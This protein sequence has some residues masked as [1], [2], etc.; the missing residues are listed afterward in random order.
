MSVLKKLASQTVLYGFTY[1]A[2]RLLNFFLTPFYTRI[3]APAAYGAVTEIYAYIAFFNVLYTYGMETGYFYF[4]NKHDNEDEVAGTTFLSLLFS[5]IGLSGLIILFSSQIA[6][7]LGY[8]DRQEYVI[9]TAL[10]L[11]F[12]TLTVI[13]FAYLRKHDKAARFAILKFANIA[14]NI[15]F[16]LFFLVLCPALLARPSYSWLHPFIDAVYRPGFGVGYVFLSNVLA[17][18][19]TLIL[20]LPEIRKIKFRWHKTLWTNIFKYSWPLLILGF[21]GMVN[22]TLDRILLKRLLLQPP[23]NLNLQQAMNELGIYSAAYKLSI[24]MTLAIQSFRYAAEPFFFSQMKEEGGKAIYAQILKYFSFITSLIFLFVMLYIPL[25]SRLLGPAFRTDEGM[26]V[27][28]ILLLA[29]LFAGTFIYLSQ[30]YKQTGKTLYGAMISVGGALITL[31]VNIIFIPYYG[32]LASAWATFACYF[33]MALASYILGQKF[34]P[35]AYN[36]GRIVWY[37]A[38]A[39]LLFLISK[40]IQES[41]FDGWHISVYMINT[42]FLLLYII[43]FLYLEKPVFLLNRIRRK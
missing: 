29:N 30:W 19:L 1:F 17:S 36:T 32:F 13:P 35:V 3:F 23:K 18:L 6:A 24:F 16:N 38:S 33:C 20:L 9:Y 21:A 22:E 27:V 15:A 42:L 34:Y 12:D 26:Q 10:I 28:P 25:F 39:T 11:A 5:S 14:F 2:G 41:I 31:V 40:F 43:Q 8:P 7:W 4:A 37:I